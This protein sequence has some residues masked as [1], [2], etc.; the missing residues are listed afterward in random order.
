MAPYELVDEPERLAPALAGL[1]DLAVVGVDV[2]RADGR[3][4]YRSAALIQVGAARGVLLIDPL[5]V[6]DLA[7]LDAFLDGRATVLHALENDVG[8]LASL[9]VTPARVH[10]T[11]LAATVLGLPTGLERLLTDLLGVDL[12]GD[13]AAMQRADWERRPLSP[14]MLEYAAGDVVHLPDLWAELTLRL[15]RTGRTAWYREELAAARARPPADERRA[16][17]RTRGASRLSP[18]A[19]SRLRA[20]WHSRE[21]LARSTDT[22]PSRIAGDK[23]LLDLAAR[24]PASASQLSRRGLRRQAVRDFGDD[25]MRAIAAAEAAQVE[26]VRRAGR[27][28]TDDDRALADRLRAIRAERAAALG[29]DPGVLCPGRAI[30]AALLT[31]P[32]TP[33]ELRE[34]LGLRP[35]QWEQLGAE[36]CDQVGLDGPGKPPPPDDPAGLADPTDKEASHHG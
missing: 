26:P 25:L 8:P 1:D 4:Y 22:A 9:G 32:R 20:L 14:A 7:S 5:A 36:F 24:P 16:W 27:S 23:V 18:S 31:D 6:A 17:T 19:R 29:L 10:D 21:E 12:G 35:W 30:L 13:K 15:D 2:E 28:P 33:E 34:G 3:R 11:A